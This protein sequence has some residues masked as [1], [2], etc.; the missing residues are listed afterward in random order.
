MN[1]EAYV[2]MANTESRHWW[3]A[4]RREILD[5][6]IGTLGLLLSARILEALH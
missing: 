6:V 5:C 4:A 3:F 1:P 2:E